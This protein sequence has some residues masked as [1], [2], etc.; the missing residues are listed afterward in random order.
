MLNE[1]PVFKNY[2]ERQAY[3]R[4]Q[5]ENRG[6]VVFVSKIIKADGTVV[7]PGRTYQPNGSLFNGRTA[8]KLISK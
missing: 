1:E 6:R 8:R 7:Q 5:Y 2:K 3:Y 4:E